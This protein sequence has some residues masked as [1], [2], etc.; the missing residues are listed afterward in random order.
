MRQGWEI[1]LHLKVLEA[2]ARRPGGGRGGGEVMNLSS[3]P[4]GNALASGNMEE[5]GSRQPHALDRHAEQ[6]PE[7]PEGHVT[8]GALGTEAGA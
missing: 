7:P 4:L 5:A 1:V 2:R 8:A 6:L 3:S